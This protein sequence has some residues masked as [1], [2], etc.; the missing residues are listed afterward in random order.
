MQT[1]TDEE[2]QQFK[3]AAD[4]CIATVEAA[5]VGEDEPF[6]DESTEAFIELV[7]GLLEK[8]EN[9]SGIRYRNKTFVADISDDEDGAYISGVR[10]FDDDG[11]EVLD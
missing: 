10:W 9:L 11:F 8:Y 5:G 2:K 1:L 3:A 7:A 6:E 4:K